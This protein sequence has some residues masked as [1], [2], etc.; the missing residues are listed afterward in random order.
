MVRAL[1]ILVEF[2][3]LC[4]RVFNARFSLFILN[5]ISVDIDPNSPANQP[6]ANYGGQ[7]IPGTYGGQPPTYGVQQPMYGG[8]QP[9]YDGQQ[10]TYDGQHQTYDGQQPSYGGQQ[11]TIQQA[12]YMPAAYQAPPEQT[13]A[14]VLLVKFILFQ[15]LSVD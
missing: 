7:Q 9:T 13:P 8:Q 10:Q 3:I 14:P 11:P 1:H 15:F 5:A 6:G 2:G 4:T 12:P